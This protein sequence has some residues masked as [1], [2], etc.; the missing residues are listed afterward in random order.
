[1]YSVRALRRA[2]GE[3]LVAQWLRHM[4]DVHS[5]AQLVMQEQ[6]LLPL[7][8]EEPTVTYPGGLHET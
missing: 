6:N 7:L 8:Q 5:V 4:K 1:M 3:T 2:K